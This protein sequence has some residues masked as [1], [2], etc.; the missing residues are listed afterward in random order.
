MTCGPLSDLEP[1]SIKEELQQGEDGHVEVKVMTWIA[2][3]GVQELTTNQTHQEKTVYGQ[4]H[5]LWERCMVIF[6]YCFS[7]E[8]DG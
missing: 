3:I 4:S 6:V 2:L 5:H 7:V 1:A 8:V